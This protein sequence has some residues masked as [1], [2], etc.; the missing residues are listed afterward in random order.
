MAW[1]LSSSDRLHT[2]CLHPRQ[3]WARGRIRR[4][5]RGHVRGLLRVTVLLH[6]CSLITDA[7]RPQEKRMS[8][9]PVCLHSGSQGLLR[10]LPGGKAT[11]VPGPDGFTLPQGN[12]QN[13]SVLG[14]VEPS[15]RLGWD[16]VTQRSRCQ[17][18]CPLLCR[19]PASAGRGDALQEPVR[20]R[21]SQ[22]LDAL[23][24]GSTRRRQQRRQTPTWDPDS[25]K[26]GSSPGSLRPAALRRLFCHL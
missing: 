7:A 10:G 5:L 16:P 1:L 26:R 8:P 25:P 23:S 9:R 12:D 20:G 4:G 22:R 15:L 14:D 24:G 21:L 2:F 19:L 13:L 6:L 17:P 18:G 11:I 3:P